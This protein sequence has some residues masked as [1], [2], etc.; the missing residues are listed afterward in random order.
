M[1]SVV[2]NEKSQKGLFTRETRKVIAELFAALPV[3][4]FARAIRGALRD[5]NAR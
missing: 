2:L 1:S 4:I 5:R 3:V